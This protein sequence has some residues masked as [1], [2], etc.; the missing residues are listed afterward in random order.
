MT[1]KNFVIATHNAH[2]AAEMSQILMPLGITVKTLTEVGVSEIPEENG[3]TFEENALIK[4][5]AAVKATGLPCIADD[6]GLCVDI[7]DGAPGVFSAR[8]AGLTNST[9]QIA[10]LLRQMEDVT[11]RAAYFYCSIVCLFPNGKK[12]S[13]SGRCDGEILPLTKGNGGFGYDP[14]FYV[15]AK[16]AT[17]AELSQDEKNELS[18]RGK[19]LRALANELCAMDSLAY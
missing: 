9:E 14:V 18:H 5:Q 8:Y 4:A 15:P 16:Q 13:V 1:E 10:H 12:I 6:S 3:V 7:L 17:F 19:A 11:N 2:K